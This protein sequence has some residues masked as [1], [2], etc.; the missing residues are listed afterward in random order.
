MNYKTIAQNI[1]NTAPLLEENIKESTDRLSLT[2]LKWMTN[3]VIHSDYSESKMCR[4]LGYVQ[5]VLVFKDFYSIEDA[6]CESTWMEKEKHDNIVSHLEIINYYLSVDFFNNEKEMLFKDFNLYNLLIQ[7][8]HDKISANDANRVLGLIQ[9]V[10][11]CKGLLNVE[12]ERDRTR[13]IFKG[14]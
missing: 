6:L 14:E 12:E 9:G 7:L 5:G 11:V 2:H 1:I 3:E 8:S 10:F 13:N 4:W